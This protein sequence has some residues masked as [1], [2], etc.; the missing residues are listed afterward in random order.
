MRWSVMTEWRPDKLAKRLPNLQARTRLQT[1]LRQ[2][3]AWLGEMKSLKFER[4]DAN[5]RDEYRGEFTQGPLRIFIRL[6][7]DGRIDSAEFASG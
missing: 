6:N 1:A 7:E 3:F 5:G 4:A 2:W